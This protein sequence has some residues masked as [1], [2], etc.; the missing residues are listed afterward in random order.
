MFT[1][2]LG[3]LARNSLRGSV[4]LRLRSGRQSFWCFEPVKKHGPGM[5]A[6]LQVVTPFGDPV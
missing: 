2:G 1:G 4:M 6:D 3:L 5:A